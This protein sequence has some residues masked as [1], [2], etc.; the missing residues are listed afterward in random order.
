MRVFLDCL[1]CM[2]QQI[3]DASRMATGDTALQQDIMEEALDIVS[4]YRDYRNAPEAV[5]DVHRIV[6]RKTGQNDP[7][8]AVKDGAIASALSLYPFLRRY[9][10]QKQDTLFWALKAAATGNIIDAAICKDITIDEGIEKELEKPFAICDIDAFR[11]KLDAAKTLLIIA[12]NAGETVFD[13]L[14]ME[15]LEGVSITYAVRDEPIINDATIEDARAS[16]IEGCVISTGCGAPGILFEEC[17]DAFLE[18]YREADLVISKGQANFE[19]LSGAD[20]EIFFLLKA[21]CPFI[22]S[23]L[24]VDVNQY[25]FLRHDQH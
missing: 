9:L 14:L 6:K 19:T 13:R 8:R 1:P 22:G 4:R 3:L 17:S 11:D 5:R 7:Y 23:H 24:G 25:V 15:R 10:D 12:D 16:G 18:I 20:R 21:K 2:V